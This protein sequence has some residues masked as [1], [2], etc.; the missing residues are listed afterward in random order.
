MKKIAFTIC[1]NNYISQALV[2]KES[3]LA[4]HPDYNF[5]IGLV[6][7]VA[8]IANI[9][10]DL[11]GAIPVC[12]LGISEFEEMSDRYNITELNTSVKPFYFEYFFKKFET[13]WVMYID[14]DICV[15]NRFEEVEDFLSRG[16]ESV[17]TPHIL[18]PVGDWDICYIREGIFNLGFVAFSNQEAVK[19]F[20][21]WWKNKLIENGYFS[22]SK[23]LFYDQL[24]MNLS[25]AFLRHVSIIYHPGYNIAGWNLF[26]RKLIQKDGTYFV[27]DLSLKLVFFHFSGVSF[28]NDD[29]YI[30]EHYPEVTINDRL[31]LKD[32]LLDYRKKVTGKN[33]KEFKLI[34]PAYLKKHQPLS[35]NQRIKFYFK[36][37]LIKYLSLDK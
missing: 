5:F 31:D 32:L 9:Y 35:F 27:N 1:S 23:N 29:A 22:Y 3:F 19:K 11:E 14:P 25:I 6:D 8:G 15:Y 16:A 12:D 2:L 13:D 10:P 28:S 17:L 24:W 36:H 21:K 20:L 7:D 18:S 30:S 33:Y 34:I 37:K 4:H 26:E